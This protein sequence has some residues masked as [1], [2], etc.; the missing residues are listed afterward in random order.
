VFKKE[1]EFDKAKV[2]RISDLPMLSSMK[3]A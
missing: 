3:Q 2:D 1:F